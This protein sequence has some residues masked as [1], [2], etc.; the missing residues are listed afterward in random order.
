M[1]TWA[2]EYGPAV[3]CALSSCMVH[4]FVHGAPTG[5]PQFVEIDPGVL[6]GAL[7][8]QMMLLS[9]GSNLLTRDAES[10]AVHL[11]TT[12]L[13]DSHKRA[14][15]RFYWVGLVAKALGDVCFVVLLGLWIKSTNSSTRPLVVYLGT[16]LGV[17]VHMA[18]VNVAFVWGVAVARRVEQAALLVFMLAWWACAASLDWFDLL[19]AADPL[20]R[21]FTV[22]LACYIGASLHR[23]FL[24]D[25]PPCAAA[26]DESEPS[27]EIKPK[28]RKK[29]D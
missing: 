12:A 22:P 6:I 17:R 8:M 28:G 15:G 21:W 27:K 24:Y 9:Y 3:I 1:L 26:A 13:F 25:L 11:A 14:L 2:E 7:V 5:W 18:S 29:D 20:T 19:G 23:L 4:E 10:N 16:L